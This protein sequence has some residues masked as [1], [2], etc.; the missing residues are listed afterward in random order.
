LRENKKCNLQNIA[1]FRS[2]SYAYPYRYVRSI[3]QCKQ[4]GYEAGS[5]IYIFLKQKAQVEG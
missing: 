1:V 2:A 3:L 5:F 4:T